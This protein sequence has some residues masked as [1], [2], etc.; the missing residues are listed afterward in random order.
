MAANLTRDQL[1]RGG[2]PARRARAAFAT[3]LIRQPN[4]CTTGTAPMKNPRMTSGD[5]SRPPPGLKLSSQP[6]SP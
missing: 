6:R 2:A 1:W 3:T 5:N 4:I